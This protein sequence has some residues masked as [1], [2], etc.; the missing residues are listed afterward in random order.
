MKS[1]PATTF[2]IGAGVDHVPKWQGSAKNENRG[3]PYIDINWRDQVE[4]STVKGLI[5]DVLHGERWHGGLIGTMVWGRSRKDLG[6]L[7]VPT[8]QNTVQG[9]VYLE[10]AVTSEASLG[11]RWRHD[12]QNTRVSYGE[13]YGELELPKIGHLEHDL[14]LSLEAMNGAGM[15]RFFGLSPEDAAHLGVASYTPGAGQSR[16]TL[17]YEGFLPTS[18][19][20]GIAFSATL[21]RLSANAANSPLVQ[22]F[23][24][25][26]QKELMAAFVY[27]F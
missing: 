14:H 6:G 8:L 15:R 4:F 5:I 21:G 24:S 1:P 17:S 25:S 18:E 27:H 10:Y 26:R 16:T 22:N 20:T 7:D 3:I 11:V 9:G 12:L 23:G 2:A 19:A 13:L